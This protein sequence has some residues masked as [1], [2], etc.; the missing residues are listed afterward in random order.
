MYIIFGNQDIVKFN[1]IGYLKDVHSL[2]EAVV[3][4]IKLIGEVR[5]YEIR[6][7]DS[8]RYHC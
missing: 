1:C 2:P 3:R 4:S 7:T 5:S 6:A 8:E